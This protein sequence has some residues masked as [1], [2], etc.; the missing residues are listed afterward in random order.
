MQ[1]N[2]NT[3]CNSILFRRKYYE[4]LVSFRKNGGD[5]LILGFLLHMHVKCFRVTTKRTEYKIFKTE[6][7]KMEWNL[8]EQ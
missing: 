5:W 1:I 8:T 3:Q 7:R 4:I 6:K 2:P